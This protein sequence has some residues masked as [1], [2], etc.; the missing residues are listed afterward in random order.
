MK[1]VEQSIWFSKRNILDRLLLYNSA[2]RD[3]RL[4]VTPSDLTKSAVQSA[5]THSHTLHLRYCLLLAKREHRHYVGIVH[6]W[7]NGTGS[8]CAA[9]KRISNSTESGTAKCTD[10]SEK[11]LLCAVLY[12]FLKDLNGRKL[13]KPR[14]KILYVP[15]E[16][17]PGC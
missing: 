4:V 17:A 11:W 8:P 5:F 7:W 14:N 9:S 10:Y 15:F 1:R 13:S 16:V 12:L 6:V 2:G 3:Q